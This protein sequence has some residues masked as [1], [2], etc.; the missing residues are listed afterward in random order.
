MKTVTATAQTEIDKTARTAFWIAKVEWDSGDTDYYSDAARTLGGIT[1][2]QRITS[3]GTA[4]VRLGTSL[5]WSLQLRDDDA[6]IRTLLAAQAKISGHR[7]T[8]YWAWSGASQV[9]WV[10]VFGGVTVAPYDYDEQAAV[11]SIPVYGLDASLTTPMTTLCDEETFPYANP[12]DFGRELPIVF[13]KRTQV[14]AVMVVGG[15]PTTI[16]TSAMTIP[17]AEA[18]AGHC[19]V[20][21]AGKF[22]ASEEVSPIRCWFGGEMIEGHFDSLRWI[23]TT[24]PI[25]LKTDQT[26]VFTD[27]RWP[28]GSTTK[29]NVADDVA[30]GHD[31]WIGDA[32][33]M[34]IRDWSQNPPPYVGP[35][36]YRQIIRH[37]D[38][39]GGAAEMTLYASWSD[40]INGQFPWVPV[41][42]P[43]S[44]VAVT[45]RA[46]LPPLVWHTQYPHAAKITTSPASHARGTVVRYAGADG[47]CVYVVNDLPSSAVT[48]AYIVYKA[49]SGEERLHAI[50][51]NYYTVNLD[52]NQFAGEIGHNVTTI[53]FRRLPEL[54]PIGDGTRTNIICADVEGPEESGAVIENPARIIRYLALNRA[55]LAEAD[56]DGDSIDAAETARTDWRMGFEMTEGSGTIADMLEDLARQAC[57]AIDWS[58]GTL[59]LV[60]LTNDLD[61]EASSDTLDDSNTVIL[62]RSLQETDNVRLVTQM[63]AK[64]QE[65]GEERR[66]KARASTA[67]DYGIQQD[68]GEEDYWAYNHGNPVKAALAFWLFRD[69]QPR[70]VVQGEGWTS[71]MRLQIGDIVTASSAEVTM[72]GGSKGW[73]SEIGY[74]PGNAEEPDA[75]LYKVDVPKDTSFSFDDVTFTDLTAPDDD[76]SDDCQ[77]S[78]ESGCTSGCTGSCQDDCTSGC[79]SGCEE[80]CTASCTTECEL[81]CEGSCESGCES[82]CEISCETGCE[83]SCETGCE[84]GCEM[85]CESNC[86]SGCEFSCETGCETSCETGCEVTCETGCQTSCESGCQVECETGA[87]S[88]ATSCEA[89]CEST[90][91]ETGCE[92]EC[93]TGAE[94]CATSCEIGCET[95]CETGCQATCETNCQTGCET[96]CETGCEVACQIGCELECETGAESCATSCEAACEGTGCEIG[97]EV[98]CETGAEGCATSCEVGCEAGCEVACQ[99][100]C[101][102]ACESTCETACQTGCET[103]CETGCETGG[104]ISCTLAFDP[105]SDPIGW[106]DCTNGLTIVANE[107]KTGTSSRARKA[108]D[109]G[110][111]VNHWA[112]VIVGATNYPN[113][114]GLGPAV[115]C[116]NLTCGSGYNCYATEYW[117]QATPNGFMATCKLVN[118]T[119]TRLALIG[120]LDIAIDDEIETRADGT[121]IGSYLND[122]YQCGVSDS[123]YT[124]GVNVGVDTCARNGTGGI[125]HF[126]AGDL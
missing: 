55:G 105:A 37:V 28:G 121:N 101:E 69:G 95:S 118:T 84:V 104:E 1:T 62:G 126:D 41:L 109:A 110:C 98:E 34:R 46:Y 88:C 31:Y 6:A 80:A 112:A 29:M 58:E 11:V 16:T 35:T 56:L 96:S 40:G 68:A 93:E 20:L 42:D 74:R 23:P 77:G 71:L 19:N 26:V 21:H 17:S 61:S 10:R 72:I 79:T 32:L 94:G 123:T 59:R 119:T 43:D 117:P 22:P 97:C 53:T 27:P 14:R 107:L 8:V 64:Y 116:Q 38:K 102:L 111:S 47:E 83:A 5:S 122:V 9:D 57:L 2:E 113:T 50:P 63:T 86:E 85:W 13:G 99:A 65:Y 115:R 91:C 7:V 103:S 36:Q 76:D 73:I 3:W 124:G 106:W 54:L 78:C 60:T 44:P 70:D 125:K 75:V 49:D 108:R 48:R 52:D 12:E 92:V 39:G 100:T 24:R 25:E 30:E 45:Y 81:A 114:T 66:V 67:S 120:S 18:D 90:G 33:A 82:G 87:E 4:V 51:S 15:G 89:A